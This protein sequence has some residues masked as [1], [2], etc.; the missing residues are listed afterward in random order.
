[1]AQYRFLRFPEGKV[2]AVT[3]SYDDGVRQDIRFSKILNAHGLKCTFNLNSAF[4]TDGSTHY[5]SYGEVREHLRDKGHEI[6]IHGERHRAPGMQRTL[7]GIRDVL[8]CRIKLE[9]EMGTVIRGMAYPDSGIKMST[10]GAAS[11]DKIRSYLSDLGVAYSRTLGGDNDAFE[12]PYDP[13]AWM[14]TA[15]HNNP[16]IFEY[17]EKFNAI[18]EDSLYISRKTAKLFYI[19]GHS[20]EFDRNDN[21]DRIEKIAEALGGRSDTWY[22]TNI[23]IHDYIEAYKSLI[24]SADERIVYNPTLTKVWFWMDNRMYSVGSGETVKL[25]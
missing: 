21:W 11:Y 13:Y 15:H 16:K 24:F 10:H 7:D 5:L 12:L 9:N 23:E 6:A 2:K 1:M 25:G 19:W 22:A 20:Y 14:P 3:L 8:N 17:I 18:N 4:I